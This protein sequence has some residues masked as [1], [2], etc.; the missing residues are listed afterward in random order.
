MIEFDDFYALAPA[1][2][3]IYRPTRDIWTNEAIDNRLPPQPLLDAS[4]KPVR[5][6]SKIKM[7][8]AS[9]ALAQ[10]RSVE[11]M[12]W[13]PGEP[14]I[15][16]GKLLVDDGWIEKPGARTYNTYLPPTIKLGDASQAQRWRDHW[17]KLYPADFTEH[18]IAWMAYRRQH[19][20]VKVNHGLVLIGA[21]GIGKDIGLTPFR[22]AVGTWNFRDIMPNDLVSKNNDFLCSIVIRVNEARDVGDANRGRIDRYGLHDHMKALM[23]SP[24]ETHRINRKYVPE[25]TSLSRAG[26]ITTSNHDDAI[27]LPSND[28]RNAIGKSECTLNDF[29]SGYFDALIHWY[30]HEHGINHVAA[31]LQQYDLTHFNPKLAPPK[32]QAFWEMVNIDRG[33]EHGELTDAIEALGE[34]NGKKLGKKPDADGNYAPP[35][36]LTIPSL[37]TVAPSLEWLVERKMSRAISHR[38]QRCGYV[39]VSN[40]KALE[41]G[42]LWKI[43]GKRMMIYARAEL[44]PDDRYT[45]ACALRDTLAEKPRE[46]PKVVVNNDLEETNP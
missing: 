21:P 9:K 15:I 2:R 25:Y 43:K 17:H 11:R 23:A 42:G 30:F 18:C 19:P 35:E 16:E 29:L 27:Y 20:E 38:I 4:G 36:A 6:G 32:T 41:S 28:R 24:P 3:C 44:S 7:I 10:R 39:P 26:F 22:D 14:E 40:R 5:V 12:T 1:N 8:P 34:Q 33:P 31:L 37:L 13:A 45:A 46:K